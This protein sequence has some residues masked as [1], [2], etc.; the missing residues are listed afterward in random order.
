MK[1]VLTI[2]VL[3]AGLLLAA[4]NSHVDSSKKIRALHKERI[5]ALQEVVEQLSAAHKNASSSYIDVLQARLQLVHAEL[6]ASE[7]AQERV[8]CLEKIVELMKEKEALL[9]QARNS[10]ST[11]MWLTL[12]A[13]ADRIKAEIA[14]EEARG[15]GVQEPK[16]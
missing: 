6:D 1:I 14:L 11:P 7:G 16:K 3:S 10:G 5:T 4:S 9:V 2:I 12:N 8:K 13:K 15:N